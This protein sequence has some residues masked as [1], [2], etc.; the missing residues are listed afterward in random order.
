MRAHLGSDKFTG[1]RDVKDQALALYETANEWAR[2][3]DED[4]YRF[5]RALIQAGVDPDLTV[6]GLEVIAALARRYILS[7]DFATTADEAGLSPD[8]L[9]AKI[10]LLDGPDRTLAMRLRLLPS[11]SP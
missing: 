8:A 2:I 9:D 3:F 5:R 11:E 1:P 7:V 4:G 10:A 6:H